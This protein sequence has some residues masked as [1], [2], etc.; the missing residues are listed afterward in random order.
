[1]KNSIDFAAMIDG[2]N[3]GTIYGYLSNPRSPIDL[4]VHLKNRDQMGQVALELA[5]TMDLFPEPRQMALPLYEKL[6]RAGEL[7]ISPRLVTPLFDRK[8]LVDPLAVPPDSMCYVIYLPPFYLV[9]TPGLFEGTL[10]KPETARPQLSVN[11]PVRSPR[12]KM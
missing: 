9:H 5:Q 10:I 12:F 3:F 11:Q 7:K 4:L 2:I 8:Y 6:L 1:M